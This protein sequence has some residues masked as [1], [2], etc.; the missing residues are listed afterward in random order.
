ML[1][2]KGW[3]TASLIIALIAVM[4][5]LSPMP[6]VTSYEVWVAI[7]AYV[8]LCSWRKY[9]IELRVIARLAAQ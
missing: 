2:T 7:L 6:Y 1:P 9:V 8:V 3:F 4:G 5:A